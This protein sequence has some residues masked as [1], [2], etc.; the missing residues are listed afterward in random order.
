MIREGIQKIVSGQ[1]LVEEE[2]SA[3]MTEIMEGRATP[4]QI[5]AFLTALR[6]KG[7]TVQE[8]TGLA[9]AM[10]RMG[11]RIHPKV[12]GRLLDTAGTGA[13]KLKTFN[14]STCSAIVTSSLGVSV[15][16]H[17]NRSVT[18]PC[19]S[20]DLIEAF[21]VRLDSSSATVE[22]SI[23][24]A[25]IGFL[26]APAFHPAMGHV[27]APRKEIGLRTVFNILGPLTNPAGA[28]SQV[29][30]VYDP[31]MI[32]V[33]AKVLSNLGCAEAMVVHGLDGVDEVSVVG[34][35]RIAW[36]RD[37]EVRVED[38]SPRDLGARLANA[39]EIQVRDKEESVKVSFMVLKGR[40]EGAKM[41]AVLVSAAAGAIVAGVAEDFPSGVKMAKE[42]ILKGHAYEKLKQ[43]VAYMGDE[44]ALKDLEEKYG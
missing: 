7:E 19:G 21:G 28:H 8:I 10:R 9:E 42:A 1:N 41:D 18:G 12:K 36:L 17:G 5:G 33:M 37:G 2:A 34:N 3:I 39:E 25:G 30:G 11:V 29:V 43:L 38:Y 44:T 13:D 31:A 23:E 22:K 26:F 15:A 4:A 27:L 40:T 16:K 32:E 14:I 24:E 35:T 6:M 20:A